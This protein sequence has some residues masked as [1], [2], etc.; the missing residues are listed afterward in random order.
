[1]PSI[2]GHTN[3]KII[4]G[5]ELEAAISKTVGL[6]LMMALNPFLVVTASC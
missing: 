3:F 4:V 1:M 5:M 2:P 6:I